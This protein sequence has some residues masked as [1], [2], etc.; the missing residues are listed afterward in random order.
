MLNYGTGNENFKKDLLSIG[1]SLCDKLN[2]LIKISRLNP[3]FQLFKTCPGFF[4][5]TDNIRRLIKQAFIASKNGNKARS[6]CAFIVIVPG[7]ELLSVLLR[8][9]NNP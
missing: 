8:T 6:A 7:R 2:H 9:I 5:C 3:Q 4:I 1:I